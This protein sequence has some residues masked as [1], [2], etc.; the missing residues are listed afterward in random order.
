MSVATL[1]DPFT[2]EEHWHFFREFIRHEKSVG[3][4][5]PQLDTMAK[6]TEGMTLREKMW[7]AGCFAATYCV[8]TAEVIF[9][10]D[11]PPP[12]AAWLREHWEGLPLRRERRA[13]RTPDKLARC[14]ADYADWMDRVAPEW[15]GSFGDAYRSVSKVWGMGRYINLKLVELLHRQG[16]H[17]F[18]QDC[19]DARGAWSPRRGMASLYPQHAEWLLGGDDLRTVSRVEG[20]ALSMLEGELRDLG[21]TWFELQVF[22]CEYKQALR[23]KKYPG[24]SHDSELGYWHRTQG[25]FG[26]PSGMPG[27]RAAIFPAEV[28]GEKQGWAGVREQCERAMVDHGYMWSDLLYDYA[29]TTNFANPV[30]R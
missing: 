19:L 6:M 14:L 4:P 10:Y 21:L 16:V 20:L 3:G 11:L 25:H 15:W 17:G 30:L 27:A 23:G 9:A 1:D 7:A 29:A 28:L 8:G 26:K 5:D 18:P 22:L 12:N 2:T 13:V 24:R